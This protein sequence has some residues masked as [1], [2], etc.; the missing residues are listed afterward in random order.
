MSASDRT[1]TL[2]NALTSVIASLDKEEELKKVSDRHGWD[3]GYLLPPS[4]HLH[5][6]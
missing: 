5:L 1:K 3:V 6:R 4:S 2:N